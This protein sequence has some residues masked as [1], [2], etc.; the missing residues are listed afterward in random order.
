[1]LLCEAGQGKS[2]MFAVTI[3]GFSVT[4][5]ISVTDAFR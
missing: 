4:I 2:P 5:S 3:F 1:M